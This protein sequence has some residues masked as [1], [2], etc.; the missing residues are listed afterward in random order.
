MQSGVTID[1]LRAR[2]T[3]SA[4]YRVQVQSDSDGKIQFYMKTAFSFNIHA[5]KSF[6]SEKAEKYF[7]ACMQS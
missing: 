3:S 2:G 5:V 4:S 1:V 6:F 7:D